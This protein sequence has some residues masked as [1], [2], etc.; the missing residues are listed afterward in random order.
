MRVS[1]FFSQQRRVVAGDCCRGPTG[2]GFHRQHS[3]K[4]RRWESSLFP[5]QAAKMQGGNPRG[6]LDV[7]STLDPQ[8]SVL[9]S[10]DQCP[11]GERL[12]HEVGYETC[13]AGEIL[14]E[15]VPQCNDGIPRVVHGQNKNAVLIENAC[16]F[17]NGTVDFFNRSE[18]VEC[19]IR[20]HKVERAVGE[21]QAPDIAHAQF[22]RRV[23]LRSGLDHLCRDVDSFNPICNLC[24]SSAATLANG[25]VEQVRLERPTKMG[26]SNPT[27]DQSP[28]QAITIG[29]PWLAGHGRRFASGKPRPLRRP[30]LRIKTLHLIIIPRNPAGEKARFA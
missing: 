6:M 24:Q 3:G 18:V 16:D 13:A 23:S 8:S 1:R 20:E 11:H 5:Q 7:T 25:F 26:F 14:R 15:G 2:K 28:V 4:E 29:S 10:P 30:A 19:R 12:S 22:H 17:P 27:L 21:I 9:H